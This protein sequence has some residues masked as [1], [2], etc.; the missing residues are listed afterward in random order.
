MSVEEVNFGVNGWFALGL[1][2]SHEKQIR[3][4]R[5]F[6]DFRSF[7]YLESGLPVATK[8]C[9]PSIQNVGYHIAAKMHEMHMHASCCFAWRCPVPRLTFPERAACRHLR[10]LC[11]RFA[12]TV[13]IWRCGTPRSW[14]HTCRVDVAIPEWETTDFRRTC[15]PA[16]CILVMYVVCRCNFWWY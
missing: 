2:V 13:S 8:P 7:N 6:I 14:R 15:Q 9:K 12:I 5:A 11:A 1:F 16:S 4:N 10:E 3:G